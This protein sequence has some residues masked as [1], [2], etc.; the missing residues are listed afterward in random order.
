MHYPR[1]FKTVGADRPGSNERRKTRGKS[2]SVNPTYS[3][4]MKSSYEETPGR[5]DFEARWRAQSWK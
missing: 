4:I 1:Q 3:S 2:G 5:A